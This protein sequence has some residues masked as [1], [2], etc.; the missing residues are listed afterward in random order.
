MKKIVFIDV[1]GTLLKDDHSLLESTMEACQRARKNGHILFL[2]T[3]RSKAELYDNILEIGFDGLVCAGG[4]YVEIEG[5]TLFHKK[6]SP[7]AVQHL[8]SYFDEKGID[9]Y[10]ESN[11]G[12]FASKNCMQHLFKV[13]KITSKEQ[14]PFTNV[15]IEN[16]DLHRE[17]INKVCFLEATVPFE[18]V[19]KEFEEDFEVL[20][21]TIPQF[22]KNSGEL[23]V[24][25]VN[26]S[27]AIEEV[28]N[29]LQID[30][31]DTIAIG[32]GMNDYDMLAYC[33][34]G[35]AMGNAKDDLKAI[36]DYVTSD[37]EEDGFYKAFEKYQLI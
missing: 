34:I 19:I 25:G 15:L 4:G 32:D 29:A 23:A 20:Q 35:I 24:K 9:F 27:R 30:K 18:E 10:L 37:I 26:K 7:E 31:K 13:T 28:L 16:E 8:V 3:G 1:D 36:A 5:N 14:H 11:G 6:V 33:E 22:G 2:C 17:D 12:L 21:C